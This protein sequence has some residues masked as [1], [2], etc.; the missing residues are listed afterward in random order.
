MDS[1]IDLHREPEKM[2][3]VADFA[4]R[5]PPPSAQSATYHSPD[6]REST[7][8]RRPRD[9]YIIVSEKSDKTLR[10]VL[11]V[12]TALLAAEVKMQE[13][14]SSKYIGPTTTY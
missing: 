13:S 3:S 6:L 1:L 4:S 2:I 9:F 10:V 8:V 12:Q 7:Y 14:E 11:L 5:H